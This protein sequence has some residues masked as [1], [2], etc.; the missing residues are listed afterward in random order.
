MD[1]AITVIIIGAILFLAHFF[2][3]LFEKTSI[4]DVLLLFLIGVLLGPVTGII[5][6]EVFGE[7]GKVFAVVTLTV[8]LFESGLSVPIK[9]LLKSFGKAVLFSL[10]TF[11]G[12]VTI[13][14]F[15]SKIVFGIS[16]FKGFMVGALL[17]GTASGIVIPLLKKIE[18]TQETRTVLNLESNIDDIL[19]IVLIF[20]VLEAS[21][22]G[23]LSV[24]DFARKFGITLFSSLVIGGVGAAVWIPL[25]KE[26]RK[27][28]NTLFTTPAFVLLL[29]G[30]AELAQGNGAL[31]VLA[32]GITFGNL[33]KKPEESLPEGDKKLGGFRL[34]GAEKSFF[35]SLVFLL[36]TYF[37]VYMGISMNIKASFL[38]WGALVTLLLFLVRGA[39]TE[40]LFRD[41]IPQFDRDVIKFMLPKGLTGMAILAL[42]GD[43]LLNDISY[44]IV[45]FS[46]LFT[47]LSLFFIRR[48]KKNLQKNMRAVP[49]S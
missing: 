2:S 38:L 3:Y 14:T 10:L 42:I 48:G 11:V 24:A 49:Y 15:L 21:K 39:I 1:I 28:K 36:K 7:T 8:I 17:W 32:F 18:V 35:S 5:D 22:V 43:P 29:Y 13:I 25:L 23:G 6:T 9:S 20:G 31:S 19:S 27:M 4:P 34:T 46:I 45:L 33:G 44:P 40:I 47:S 26:V 30:I 37:F 41:T 12:T 16:Y